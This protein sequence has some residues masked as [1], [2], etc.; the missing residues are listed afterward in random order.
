MWFT[1]MPG[2]LV[3]V[4]E[5]SEQGI[6]TIVGRQLTYVRKSQAHNA[7]SFSFDDDKLSGVTAFAA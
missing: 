6:A 7:M 2:Y 4:P 1:G 5:V 3:Y